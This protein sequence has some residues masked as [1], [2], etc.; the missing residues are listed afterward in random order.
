MAEEPA[1]FTVVWSTTGEPVTHKQQSDI[2]LYVPWAKG[3]VY[4]DMKG[5]V[6]EDDGTLIL[7]DECGNYRE[8]PAGLFRVIW[9]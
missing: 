8:P 5:F 6:V 7:L 3:L 9:R 2:A 4:C 1:R